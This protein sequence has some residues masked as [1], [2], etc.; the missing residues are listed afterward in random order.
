MSFRI[1]TMFARD[2][3]LRICLLADTSAN[4]LAQSLATHVLHL[5]QFLYSIALL[6]I[7]HM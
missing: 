3:T 5:V 7:V 4:Q 1:S 6:A 2:C